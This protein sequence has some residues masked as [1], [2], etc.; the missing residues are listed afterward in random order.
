MWPLLKAKLFYNML[1][2]PYRFQTLIDDSIFRMRNYYV[3]FNKSSYVH[4]KHENMAIVR[5]SSLLVLE[6]CFYGCCHPCF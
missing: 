1:E 5:L 6:Y 3:T 4:L 2:L